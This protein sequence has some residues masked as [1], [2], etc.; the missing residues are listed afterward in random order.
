MFPFLRS[1]IASVAFIGLGFSS[2]AGKEV[3]FDFGNKS[4]GSS[5]HKADYHSARY[6]NLGYNYNFGSQQNHQ[7]GI[8][9]SNS[10]R[11]IKKKIE[12]ISAITAISTHYQFDLPVYSKNKFQLR[13]G[14]YFENQFNLNF[15][16]IMDR[17]YFK[18][19]NFTEVGFNLNANYRIN[20]QNMLILKARNSIFTNTFFSLFHRFGEEIKTQ[21]PEKDLQ[22]NFGTVN[23]FLNLQLDL[24]YRF[25]CFKSYWGGVFVRAQQREFQK[26]AFQNYNTKS[27]SVGFRFSY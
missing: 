4:Y 20:K 23:K 13:T 12:Y 25:P 21:S 6:F 2:Q 17:D 9:L 5:I 24:E 18:W 19:E 26:F 14:G 22:Q 15:L 3:S 11:V 1:I 8:T 7:L 16:P 10:N 27:I